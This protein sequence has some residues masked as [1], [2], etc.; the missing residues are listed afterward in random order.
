MYIDI[1]I[2]V[3]MSFHFLLSFET[4]NVSRKLVFKSLCVLLSRFR[5]NSV[6]VVLC[7]EPR[8]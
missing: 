7:P 8:K 2:C 4:G 3:C 5:A 6:E 1:Y